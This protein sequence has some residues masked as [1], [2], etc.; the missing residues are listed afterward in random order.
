MNRDVSI[1][2]KNNDACHWFENDLPIFNSALNAIRQML[3]SYEQRGIEITCGPGLFSRQLGIENWSTLSVSDMVPRRNG[4]HHIKLPFENLGLDFIF[5]SYCDDLVDDLPG[6]FNEVYRTLKIN[7]VLV[8]AFVDPK[9][10]SGKRYVLDSSSNSGYD[11][12]QIMFELT[13][14]GFKHF[15]VSQ[16]LFSAP[17]EIREPQTSKT[18]YGEGSFLVVQARKKI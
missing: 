4:H 9:S 12:E 16:T 3:P 8:V 11:I 18:G 1:G 7:G 14:A 10:P 2:K 13:H 15:E 6:I 17:E 5:L